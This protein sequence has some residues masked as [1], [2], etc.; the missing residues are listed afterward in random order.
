LSA[1]RLGAAPIVCPSD[2][3]PWRQVLAVLQEIPVSPDPVQ[4]LYALISI[5]QF[6]RMGY[7]MHDLVDQDKAVIRWLQTKIQ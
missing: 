3:V 2:R 5:G 4:V 7:D 6:V 1:P